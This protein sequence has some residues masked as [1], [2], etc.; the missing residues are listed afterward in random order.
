MTNSTYDKLKFLALC[1]APVITFISAILAIWNVPYTQEITASLAAL[2][3]LVS[4]VVAIAKAIYDKNNA[5]VEDGE[6]DG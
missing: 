2:S 6:S 5:K 3:T 1:I 4:A